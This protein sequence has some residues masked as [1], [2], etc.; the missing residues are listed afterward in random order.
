MAIIS[1]EDFVLTYDDNAQVAS[2]RALSNVA[3]TQEEFGAQCFIIEIIRGVLADGI[4][5]DDWNNVGEGFRFPDQAAW[6]VWYGE[7]RDAAKERAAL[8]VA[9]HVADLSSGQLDQAANLAANFCERGYVAVM[10]GTQQADK[11]SFTR[12]GGI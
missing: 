10:A 4:S 3:P 7:I 2:T 9:S 6:D 8:N 1:N 11:I 5:L 12:L